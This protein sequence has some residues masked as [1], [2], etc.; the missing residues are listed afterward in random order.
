MTRIGDISLLAAI[1]IL[2]AGPIVRW[3]GQ[4]CTFSFHDIITALT[5]GANAGTLNTGLLVTVFFL[6][7]GGAIAKSAQFPLF[8]WLYSA[9]EA[10]TS[11]SALLTRCHNG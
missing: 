4:S 11:V 8:T 1:G 5:A 7:L 10:P 3:S 9:M 2:Y 6:V